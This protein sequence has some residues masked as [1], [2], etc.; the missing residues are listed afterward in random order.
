MM[1]TRGQQQKEH[2]I[3]KATTLIL[4]ERWML[5]LT[6]RAKIRNDHLKTK[7]LLLFWPKTLMNT[8]YM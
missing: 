3:F 2:K 8:F 1:Q 6:C 5:K 7:Q 4:I